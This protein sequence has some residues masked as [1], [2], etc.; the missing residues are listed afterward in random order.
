MSAEEIASR[1]AFER[2]L[3]QKEFLS[4]VLC[5]LSIGHA[6]LVGIQQLGTLILNEV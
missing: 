6:Q 5:H 2:L 3:S 4:R 1:A